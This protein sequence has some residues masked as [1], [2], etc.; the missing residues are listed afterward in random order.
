M[1]GKLYLLRLKSIL[2]NPTLYFWTLIFPFILATLFQISFGDY[3][4][5]SEDENFTTV[6]VAV[7][8]KGNIVN[9]NFESVL[10][11]LSKGENELL[12]V[13]KTNEKEAKQMLEND[14]I[15]G[16]ITIADEINLT[17]KDSG[18]KQ[19]ILKTIIDNY[20]QKCE[21]M[22]KTVENGGT[23]TVN[24]LQN[25][26]LDTILSESYLKEVSLS[27]EVSNPMLTFFYAII[28]M[29][30][31]YS[32]FLGMQVATDLQGNVSDLAKRRIVAPISKFA[33]LLCDFL[34]SI[35]ISSIGMLLLFAYLIFGFGIKFGSHPQLVL[36]TA[37]VGILVGMGIGMLV[38]SFSKIGE[39]PKVGIIIGS[40]M[41]SC[42]LSGLMNNNMPYTV[43]KNCPII[44]EINPATL[45]S[46]SFYCL[47][48]YK[49]Y[50]MYIKNMITLIVIAISLL[51]ISA[52]MMRRRKYASL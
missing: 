7:V 32:C 3:M 33:S 50:G 40:V 27:D 8:N 16:I 14:K 44:S 22:E 13:T 39:G 30:C 10:D 31:L 25:L 2:K 41:T 34:A 19:T 48:F 18:I 36:L 11:S 29:T 47:T 24:I 38:G 46:N 45:I 28:A 52:M 26:D 37:F 35:T 5:T 49:D 1:F 12:N 51:V 43:Q 15:E 20:L 21:I 23:D 4:N 42:F 6:N 9:Q 17:V